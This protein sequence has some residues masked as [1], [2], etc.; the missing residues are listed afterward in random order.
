MQSF[1]FATSLACA[2]SMAVH[3]FHLAGK[4][5]RGSRRLRLPSC[6]VF[7]FPFEPLLPSPSTSL[8]FLFGKGQTP[9]FY[10]THLAVDSERAPPN[11][12]G[13]QNKSKANWSASAWTPQDPVDIACF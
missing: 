2:H 9:R 1:S 5:L 7:A 12:P 3:S 8:I 10:M 13:D 11:V 6:L 4:P